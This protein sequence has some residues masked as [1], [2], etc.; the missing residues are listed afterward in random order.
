MSQVSIDN[1]RAAVLGQLEVALGARGLKSQ[2][3]TDDFDLL[4]EGVIDSLGI[5]TLITAVE[6]HFAI[7]IDFEELAPEQLTV[8]G[9]FCRYVA[10]KSQANGDGC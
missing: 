7:Q 8:I 6:Q 9:P 1:V 10:A 3:V 2:D 5:V 4:T